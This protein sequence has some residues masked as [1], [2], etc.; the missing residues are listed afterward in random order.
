[1]LEDRPCILQEDIPSSHK[2]I[3]VRDWMVDFY[4]NLPQTYIHQILLTLIP[5]IITYGERG[6]LIFPQYYFTAQ[7]DLKNHS[8]T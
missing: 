3:N 8:E 7:E 1:M 2:V 4:N 5:W 6:L